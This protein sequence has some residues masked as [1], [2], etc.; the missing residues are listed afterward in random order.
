MPKSTLLEMSPAEQAQLR[1]ALRR[2]RDGSLL[3]LHSRLLCAV[4]RHPTAMA[5]V[6]CCAR[7]RVYR[8]VRA[9]RAGTLGLEP[10]EEGRLRPPSRTTV[11]VP[12]RRRALVAL[13]KA[14]PRADGWCRTR[15]RCAP[16]AATLP[17]TRGI[18]VAA[19]TLRRGGPEVGWGWK[20]AKLVAQDNDPQR[21]HRRARIRCVGEPLKPSAALGCADER[22]SHW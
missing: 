9:Y 7:S 22:A 11:L 5:A 12:P 3:G 16:L 1:A 14:A 8:T 19:A 6:L 13:L 4:G 18:T 17:T 20:R 21:V 15:W 2:A 10:D